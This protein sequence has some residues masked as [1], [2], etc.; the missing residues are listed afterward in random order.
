MVSTRVSC[1]KLGS[2]ANPIVIYEDASDDCGKQHASEQDHSDGY[3]ELLSTP[4]FCATF[5]A[6]GSHVP[7]K[8]SKPVLTN[9]TCGLRP[10][11]LEY[12]QSPRFILSP[13][14]ESISN[15]CLEEERSEAAKTLKIEESASHNQDKSCHNIPRQC[16]NQVI[17][18][19]FA[20]TA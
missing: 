20:Y 5:G 12:G 11:Q 17:L 9:S 10:C 3:T 14:L 1:D 13:E 8:N 19:I 6:G 2:E 18:P 16:K 7:R 15:T 4:E